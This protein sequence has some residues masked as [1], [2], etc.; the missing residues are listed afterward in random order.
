MIKI[1]SIYNNTAEVLFKNNLGKN[2]IFKLCDMDLIFKG[3]VVAIECNQIYIDNN[4]VIEE[5]RHEDIRWAKL[6]KE[7]EF[8]ISCQ[9]AVH[10]ARKALGDY[11]KN[12]L[13]KE[14][15][16]EWQQAVYLKI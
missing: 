15:D 16:I 5:L 10:Q 14:G 11:A 4:G 12:L 8:E 6:D 1:S 13:N 3:R 2:M 9:E 7:K